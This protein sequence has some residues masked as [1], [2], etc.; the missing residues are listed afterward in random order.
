MTPRLV[1]RT[2]LCLLV[3]A[4][5][6]SAC[7]S[8]NQPLVEK[9][10]LPDPLEAGWKGAPVCEQLE[11]TLRQRVLK[12]TFEPGVGHE[13]HFH[14]PHA[15]YALSGGRMRLHDTSGTREVDLATGSHYTSDGTQWH[16]VLN[17]GSTTVQYLIIES[18]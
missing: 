5:I 11:L 4:G 12:C 18:L 1:L 9:D 2:T 10:K 16:E 15:G 14:A 6:T 3:C 8:I 7:T 17:V 13:R